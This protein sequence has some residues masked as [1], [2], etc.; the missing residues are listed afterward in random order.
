MKF[1]LLITTLLVSSVIIAGCS[2]GSSESDEPGTMD[3]SNMTSMEGMDHSDMTDEE[4]EEMDMENGHASH[5]NIVALNNSTGENELV[6]PQLIEPKDGIVNINAKQGT[7]E[8]FKGIQTKTFGYN[9]SF[10]GPVIRVNEGETVILRTKNELA[11][12]T[13]FHWHGVDIP[14]EGDGGPHQLLEP[15]AVE[16]VKFTVSRGLQHFGSTHIRKVLLLNKYIKV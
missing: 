9:G 6:L 10:L 15:G 13:T 16:D 8:I 11:E 2:A 1:N 7:T 5:T 3:H 14:G 4:M 12:P